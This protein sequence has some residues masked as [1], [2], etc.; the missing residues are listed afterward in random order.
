M[1]SGLTTVDFQRRMLR[2][3]I[4]G[5][6]R[7]QTSWKQAKREEGEKI[8]IYLLWLVL[9]RVAFVFCREHIS[10]SYIVF[11]SEFLQ[12]IFNI[13]F[14]SQTTK[15]TL[16]SPEICVHTYQSSRVEPVVK[17]RRRSREQASSS[18]PDA[19]KGLEWRHYS[20]S[21]FCSVVLQTMLTLKIHKKFRFLPSAKKFWYFS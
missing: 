20:L 14:Y 18:N 13:S 5:I 6:Y 4:Q 3:D 16:E 1:F 2:D 17:R 21:P 19:S 15:G 9:D 11:V 8:C 10:I 7:K 12:N